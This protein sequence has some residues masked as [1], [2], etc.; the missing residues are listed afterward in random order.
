M[1]IDN[2]TT[3]TG[4][5]T[6]EPSLK[7]TPGGQ[8]VT[9]FGIAVNR[10]WQNRQTQEWEEAVS[11]FD[12]VCWAQLA[13]NVSESVPKGGRVTVTGRLD[14]RS[15]ETD[16][17]EKRSKIEIVADDVAL[18]LR[19]ATVETIIRNEPAENQ[20][21]QSSSSRR[22]SEASAP[23]Y[24]P[25]EEPFHMPAEEWWPGHFGPDYPERLLP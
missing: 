2:T 8:A 14:Q 1:A 23:A 25:D 5:V 12:V 10:R 3:V 13:E 20:G 19:W 17:G 22:K 11:F 6:I 16:G 18:S 4:N 9:N 15:W 24:N 21:R 7:Y